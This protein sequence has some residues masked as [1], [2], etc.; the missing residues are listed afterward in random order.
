MSIDIEV[1]LEHDHSDDCPICRTTDVVAF[2]LMPA[3]A[4]WEQAYELPH[5]SV[6]LHGAAQFLGVMM[7][8]GADRA[9]LENALGVLLD[10]IEEQIAEDRTLG[11][12][13]QGNA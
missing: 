11:G 3:A 2:T 5:L 9:D 10:D 13:T 12:P 7:Q 8:E 6:A 4:S 1:L